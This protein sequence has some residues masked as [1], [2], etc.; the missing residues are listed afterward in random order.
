MED[1]SNHSNTNLYS[2]RK[3]DSG[4]GK[5]QSAGFIIFSE[6]DGQRKYLVLHYLSGRYDFAQG[7][8]EAGE[9][10]MQAALREL[11][12]ET[13]IDQIEVI[14]RFAVQLNYSFRRI[15]ALINKTTTIFLAH[16]DQTDVVIS[17]EHQGF[18]WLP[19]AEAVK[20]I[21]YDKEKRVLIDADKYLNNLEN[22]KQ[23]K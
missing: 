19:Y 21:T 15:Y 11:K 2:H 8:L 22:L 17:S 9:D 12:E 20:I 5:E 23:N 6:I 13:G 1:N 3:T 16:T 18:V 7:H 14:P 4:L 10:H